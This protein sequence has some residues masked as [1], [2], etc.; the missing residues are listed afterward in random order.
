MDNWDTE[1]CEQEYTPNDDPNELEDMFREY[2]QWL[3]ES[4]DDIPF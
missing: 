1:S 3:A 4:D 2:F